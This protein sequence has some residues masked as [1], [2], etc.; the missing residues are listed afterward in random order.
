M[1][2]YST[3]LD[4]LPRY[5]FAKVG[6]LSR[7]VEARDKIPIINARI[8]IPDKEAPL[9][10]KRLMSDYILQGN[11]TYG[12]PVDVHPERGINELIDAIIQHYDE[13]H[14]VDL[15]PENIAVTG[16]S[17]EVLHNLARVFGR[18]NGVIP[19][20]VYPA[21][22]G[23]TIL[24][25]N[26]IRRIPTSKDS[27]WLPELEFKEDDVFLYFCD[28]NNPTGSVAKLKYYEEL[29]EK[30]RRH[31]IGGIFDKAYKDYTF[32]DATKLVSIT[33]VPEL[34]RYGYEVVSYSK[35]YN[36]VGIGLGWIVSNPENITRWLNL[37]SQFSQGV[38]WFIQKAG[39]EAL[40]NLEVKREMAE[41]MEELKGRRDALVNGFNK[42]G[43]KCEPPK[44]TPYL[45]AEVPEGR[46]DEDFVLN[47]L[48]NK[49]H[50]AVMPGSYFGKSG[51]GYFRAT[52]F[53][54]KPKIDEAIS[55]I[56]VIKD[57]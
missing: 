14:G 45:W 49:A 5:P 27:G 55:R 33:Q 57:W 52:V 2:R 43:L 12:Y 15:K 19:E 54:P 48:L 56:E 36:F 44:A 1:P 22:E 28:P 18:G 24:S 9:S 21:Y 39:V 8:G 13:R 46:N 31:D 51:R 41:Y 29:L 25:G 11:S 50:V 34:M 23:A 10:I 26:K 17:K 3:L 16:W 6:G 32:D 42:L 47:R 40:T 30:M 4:A 35:H 7:E 20:P 37:S 53:L 38:P